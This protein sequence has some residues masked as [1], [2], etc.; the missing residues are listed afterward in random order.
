[1][2]D[3]SHLD[4]STEGTAPVFDSQP[5]GDVTPVVNTPESEPILLPAPGP[6]PSKPPVSKRMK[7]LLGLF[8]AVILVSG[9]ATSL[10]LVRQKQNISSK[11]GSPGDCRCSGGSIICEELNDDG[12]GTHAVWKGDDPS[13]QS[14]PPPQFA[15]VYDTSGDRTGTAWQ[16]NNSSGIATGGNTTTQAD[17][18]TK[19]SFVKGVNGS[20]VTNG[21]SP[22]TS[23]GTFGSYT[24]ENG[25]LIPGDLKFG[26]PAPTTCG[27]KAD[28][29]TRA[30]W[31][32]GALDAKDPA[33]WGWMRQTI[34]STNGEVL[35]KTVYTDVAQDIDTSKPG[36]QV[37]NMV[38]DSTTGLWKVENIY[39]I[40]SQPPSTFCKSVETESACWARWL[41][42]TKN[43]FTIN[44]VGTV[45]S[46]GQISYTSQPVSS[47]TTNK[48]IYDGGNIKYDDCKTDGAPGQWWCGGFPE[49]SS[50]K[51]L[52]KNGF[53]GLD[54]VKLGKNCN[55]QFKANF[56]FN[57]TGGCGKKNA[58]GFDSSINPTFSESG[59]TCNYTSSNID[60]FYWN[61]DLYDGFTNT[62][63]KSDAKKVRYVCEGKTNL[64]EGCTC[65]KT[66][67]GICTRIEDSLKFDWSICGV[68]QIDIDVPID[69]A[70]NV[71]HVS[72]NIYNENCGTTPTT[73]T[74]TG[75]PPAGGG[76]N[77]PTTTTFSGP[78]P[79]PTTTTN[80]QLACYQLQIFRVQTPVTTPPTT[81]QIQ[82]WQI[83]QGDA[84]IFRGFASVS[85]GAT[86]SKMRFT[87]TVGG[88][89]Q[90]PVDVNAT[91][92][93]GLYQADYNYTITQNTSY[94][95]TTLPI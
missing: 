3:Q 43:S 62:N 54:G 11:A 32:K 66:I 44:P 68:Q 26:Q 47:I 53:C 21:T 84:L 34:E 71:Y 75:G 50:D 5:V 70:G 91:L 8:S 38:Y 4:Y 33:N 39:D 48:I 36:H 81:V 24:I 18:V 85:G 1:M 78:T 65:E 64:K 82:P 28:C 60:G 80:P 89:A 17:D 46:S 22:F 77:P 41:T 9:L 76:D 94:S 30:D 31:E 59:K 73:F 14:G 52:L 10:F 56:G 40:G 69:A 12:N 51:P 93:G 16:S 7:I 92:V 63:L 95:V 29:I 15:P 6:G 67:P 37:G 23:Q 20:E 79:T 19:A 13:C 83:N 74:P 57:Y 45:N 90:T 49:A 27:F 87:V 86:V 55:D 42:D 61:W 2:D 88:V 58:T 25:K 72:R 35:K